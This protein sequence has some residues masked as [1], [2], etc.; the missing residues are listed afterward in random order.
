M[1]RATKALAY[2]LG[3]LAAALGSTPLLKA[4]KGGVTP[5]YLVK[6]L[7]S[8]VQ[9]FVAAGGA[10]A[11]F[12]GMLVRAPLAAIAGAAGAL[13]AAF[14]VGRSTAPHEG[15]ERA[16]GPHWERR[17]PPALRQHMLQQR[18]T[19]KLPP[20][21]EP[22]WRRDI[23]F[24]T[25]PGTQR[26]LLCDLW[27]PP[28]GVPPSR[29]AV[30]YFHGS[31]WHFGDKD[32]GTRTTFRHLAAQGHVVMDVAYRLYPEAG[33]HGIIGDV[34]RA[35]AWMKSH[36]AEYGVDPDRVVLSGGSAGAH[37]ALLAAYAPRDPAMIP[38]D[39]GAVDLSVRAVVSWHGT[40]D[41]ASRSDD[42]ASRAG[43]AKP[44]LPR[45]MTRRAPRLARFKGQQ[46]DVRT[47]EILPNLFGG[48]REEVPD[49]YRLAAPISH[50][51]AGCPPTL[52]LQG[53][54][55]SLVP[56]ATARALYRRLLEAG[57]PAVYVE[58]PHTEHAFDVLAFAAYSPPAQAAL[59]DL[60]RFLA[61]VV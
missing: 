8:S 46:F 1:R 26:Q 45:F 50:V 55:D 48:R 39:V 19:W 18:W 23:P 53:E 32:L 54:D 42:A 13:L 11:A 6:V 40:S 15:F 52:L 14:Y 3:F 12:L 7:A 27:Q 34:K 43:R 41:F 35:I 24:W 57:V 29:L 49:L 60:D 56:A 20:A 37:L 58:F 9:A 30:L 33:F 47:D 5:L 51:H 61:L 38:E 36:A 59:Y 25:I 4:R 21:P 17:I 31:G 16:F 2:V 10:V 28:L 44:F 22:R